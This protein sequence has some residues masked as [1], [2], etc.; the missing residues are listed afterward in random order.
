MTFLKI[1]IGIIIIILSIGLYNDLVENNKLTK[2]YTTTKAVVI[3]AHNR[4]NGDIQDFDL[5][6]EIDSSM[7]QVKYDR[8][9]VRNNTY[10]YGDSINISY[11]KQHPNN[12]VISGSLDSQ[13]KNNIIYLSIAIIALLVAVFWQTLKKLL[14]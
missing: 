6:F 12:I 11:E 1:F 9:I 5:V 13:I 4:T 8:T 3:N 14:L 7:R 10:V 2:N